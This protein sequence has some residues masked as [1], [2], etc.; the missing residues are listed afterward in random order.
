MSPCELV[1]IDL[2]KSPK[3]A[4]Y[5]LDA[6]A[7]GGIPLDFHEGCRIFMDFHHQTTHQ[8]TTGTDEE[9]ECDATMAKMNF[10]FEFLCKLHRY[11]HPP[12]N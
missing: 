5:F 9:G 8:K 11:L 2:E 10:A 4:A 7:F 3:K 12:K 6:V 1:V